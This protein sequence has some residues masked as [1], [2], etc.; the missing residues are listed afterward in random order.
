MENK[1]KMDYKEHNMKAKM[2]VVKALRD[3]A[4][5]M[6]A[7]EVNPEDKAVV[8]KVDVKK[9]DKSELADE[10]S[11]D[12]NGLEDALE[13]AKEDSEEESED[14]SDEDSQLK[15]LLLKKLGRE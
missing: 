14:S 1:K 5:E 2:D 11:E 12:E 15:K 3:M 8:A 13:D 9:V 10:L 4:M 7:D 6:M